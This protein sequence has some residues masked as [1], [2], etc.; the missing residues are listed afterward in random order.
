MRQSFFRNWKKWLSLACLALLFPIFQNMAP[1]EDIR[2][3]APERP[4]GYLVNPEAVYVPTDFHGDSLNDV[5]QSFWNY[6][7]GDMTHGWEEKLNPWNSSSSFG[8][9]LGSASSSTEDEK[10]GKLRW[11]VPNP[12]LMRF[13]YLGVDGGEGYKLVCDV[14]PGVSGAR[15][16]FSKRLDRHV[17]LEVSHQT[18][19]RQS[20]IHMEW[21]W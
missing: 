9:S 14:G 5:G 17:N 19:D 20:Q 18:A 4:E 21:N 11:G 8:T 2:K 1:W 10:S 3:W 7:F 12:S 6:N 15:F 16:A 13:S